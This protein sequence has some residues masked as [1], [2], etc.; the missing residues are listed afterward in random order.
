MLVCRRCEKRE[1]EEVKHVKMVETHLLLLHSDD[2]KIINCVVDG[3]SK[4]GY[5]EKKRSSC[6]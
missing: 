6:V 3:N 1:G 5:G 4:G 2:N